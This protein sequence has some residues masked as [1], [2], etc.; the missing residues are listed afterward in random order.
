MKHRISG[1][2]FVLFF[3]LFGAVGSLAQE[4]SP[5]AYTPVVVPNG[6]TLPFK[7][8]DGVKVFHLVAE[9]VDHEFAP[10]LKAKCWGYNGRTPGPVIEAVEG[11]RIRIY[12]SNK[13]PEATSVHW[14]GILLPNGMDG[15]AGLSQKR[16]E[17][18]ETF[19]YEFTLKQHGTFMYHPHFD[20]MVQIGLGMAGLFVIHP[21]EP[22]TPKVDRDFAFMVAEWKV[23]AGASRPDPAEMTEFNTLTINSKCFPG[24]APLVVKKGDRVRFRI[25]NL[26]VMDHH[27]IH[28]HGF[29]FKVTAT[30][31]GT[32]PA[33]GQWPETT[34]LVPVGSTR[35]VQFVADTPG[36]WALHCHMIHHLMNQMGH[37]LPN[38]IGI[39]DG[40]V[41]S[42]DEKVRRLL[43]GYMTMG[44]LGM[45]GMAEMG[46]RV[47]SNSIPMIGGE[48]PHGYIDMGGMFTIL[49][50]RE[51]IKNYDQDP[52][53]YGNP[54][55]TE[56]RPATDAELKAD[57]ILIP[58]AEK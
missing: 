20:E 1:C 52:G 10:G 2:V 39:P 40:D 30:D 14:H 35:D 51:N 46:M 32:I 18:G 7:I 45:G 3:L 9:P 58:P 24:T 17:P 48:G 19:R 44:H 5:A 33:A 37:G 23:P 15:V 26:S 11:D 28:L 49:K 50:V 6:A 8:V 31:G 47:P 36:D 29:N 42:F 54:P 22:E 57:G 13:L 41:Q 34:V 21:R 53:W 43:A 4:T 55:G 56:A 38:L 27:P 16:I 25:G 12:V